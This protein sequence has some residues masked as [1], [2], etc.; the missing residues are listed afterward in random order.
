M[1]VENYCSRLFPLHVVVVLVLVVVFL[2]LGVALAVPRWG[3]NRD[4]P[5][6]FGGWSWANEN[7]SRGSSRDLPPYIKTCYPKS[8][9]S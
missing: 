1:F 3:S 8:S 9:S 7:D 5:R 2:L 6:Y 4:P